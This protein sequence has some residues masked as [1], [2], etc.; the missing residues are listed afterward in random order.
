MHIVRRRGWEVSERS[1][2]PEA[3]VMGRRAALAGAGSLAI[4]AP[5]LAQTAPATEPNPK[6]P[7]GRDLTPEKYSTTYN[8]YYEF[9]DGKTLWQEAQALKQRPWTIKLD[10]MLKQPVPSTSTI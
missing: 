8:N 5:A 10:G 2:T 1:V 7:A 3:L 6:Y 9:S 4:A